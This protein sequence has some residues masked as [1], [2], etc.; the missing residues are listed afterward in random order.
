MAVKLTGWPETDGLADDETVV[1]E[2]DCPTVWVTD[3]AVLVTKP[4]SPV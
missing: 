2:P 3:A 4:G 1:A